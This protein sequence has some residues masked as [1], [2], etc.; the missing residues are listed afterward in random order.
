MLPVPDQLPPSTRRFVN[1]RAEL[2]ALD[3]LT[4]APREG[5]TPVVI[6][7]GMSGVGKTA[8]S[9]H[10]AHVNRDRFPDGRLYA[11]LGRGGV[12]IGDVL[13]VFLQVLGVPLDAIPGTLAERVV[14][15]RSHTADKRLLVLLD[16]VEHAA[17][18]IPLIPSLASGS[19]VLVTSRAALEELQVVGAGCV[20][21]SPL[22]PASARE[23]LALIIGQRRV[24]AEPRALEQLVEIAAGLPLA[25]Q[26]SG[27]QLALDGRAPVSQFV[28]DLIDTAQQE[29]IDV[30][31]PGSVDL[32]FS[33]AYRALSPPAALLYRRLGAHPGPSF[34]SVVAR[35]AAGWPAEPI[36]GLLHELRVGFLIDDR[37]NWSRFHEPLLLH[38]RGALALHEP[39]AEAE[40]ASRIVAYYADTVERMGHSID[41]SAQQPAA[42]V[43]SRGVPPLQSPVEAI[44]WFEAERE[45]LVAVLRTATERGW[46]GHA[47][48][49]AQ[50]L[51]PAYRQRGHHNEA[52]EVY[53]L[54]TRA[55]QRS[56]DASVEARMRSYLTRT[57]L[58]LDDPTLAAPDIHRDEETVINVPYEASGGP[59]ALLRLADG[60]TV[61]VEAHQGAFALVWPTHLSLTALADLVARPADTR[62]G[63]GTGAL[64]VDG[65]G[66]VQEGEFAD[67]RAGI[68]E[69]AADVEFARLDL[70]DVVVTWQQRA[71]PALTGA[72]EA[73]HEIG[74]GAE[75]F[76]PQLLRELIETTA[77]APIARAAHRLVEEARTVLAAVPAGPLR[78]DEATEAEFDAL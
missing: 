34:T 32:V 21:L 28:D 4:S 30:R 33:G 5:G 43:A 44:T 51:W 67:L 52:L 71:D 54:S 78:R 70:A 66:S 2:D 20:E 61:R 69:D 6:I 55:A 77:V 64:V 73:A 68:T 26:I 46:D 1:R 12:G 40:A 53:E 50:A 74:L 14:L 37:G 27:A 56:G 39:E 41:P 35:A 60:A 57:L 76:D 10:W 25:L 48:R 16:D 31:A 9:R 72:E 17:Q 63:A 47:F 7:R 65:E 19:V 22:D 75:C 23:L 58:A 15:F 8:T 42:S 45:N 49:I 24:G 3:R 36:G 29:R 62:A 18:V 13:A 11:D 59:S 38:A